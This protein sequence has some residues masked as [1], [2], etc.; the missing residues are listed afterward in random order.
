M[1]GLDRLRPGTWE[2]D[3]MFPDRFMHGAITGGVL[4]IIVIMGGCTTVE[5]SFLGYDSRQ[6]W[7]AMVAVARTPAYDD[8]KI[9]ANDVWVDEREY[10][11]EVYRHLRRVLYSPDANPHRESRTW[12]FEIRLVEFDPPVAR[13]VSRGVG[14][15]TDAQR[16]GKRYFRDVH[17]VLLG[18]PTEVTLPGNDDDLLESLG[19]GE[20][21]PGRYTV[22]PPENH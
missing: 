13:L 16:E 20:T 2:R 12:R 3:A 21:I 1:T 8:W 19:P 15:P 5:H 10:R 14:Q 17:D 9:A 4:V 6:V 11:I 18:V 22:P 7:T